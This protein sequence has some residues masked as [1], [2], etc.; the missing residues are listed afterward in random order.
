MMKAN[1][2]ILLLLS[3]VISF[4]QIKLSGKV[5]DKKGNSLIGANVY[6]KNTYF[7]TSTNADGKYTLNIDLTGEQVLVVKFLGYKTIEK[8]IIL[9]DK[10]K[11]YDIVLSEIINNLNSV[12]ITA[13]VF[14][15]S[16]ERKGV[17]LKSL[18]ILTTSSAV[19]DVYGAIRTLPGVHNV[20]DDGRLFVRGGESYETKNFID[21]MLVQNANAYNS[22]VPNLPTRGR[23]SPVL[24]KGISF[25]SG[26]YS[27]EYGQA[28]SS[29]LILKTEGLAD[30]TQTNLSFLSVGGSISHTQRWKNSSLAVI[31]DYKNLKPYYSIFKQNIEWKKYPVSYT[32]TVIFRQKIRK[33]GLFKVFSSFQN[34]TKSII[35]HNIDFFN[36][37]KVISLNN[38]NMY[39][40]ATY[41][42]NY[43]GWILKT[44]VSYSYNYDNFQLGNDKV[45][46]D[47]R[48]LQSKITLS[49]QIFDNIKITFGTK[50][51][52]KIYLQDYYSFFE[53]KNYKPSFNDNN[54]AVFTEANMQL[55]RLLALRIGGRLEYSTLLKKYN[56]APRFSFALKISSKSQF[57][58]AGGIFY[59]NPQNEYLRFTNNLDFE[60][61]IHYVL[62]YQ[63]TTD[64]RIFRVELY[65][66]DYSNLIKFKS[67]NNL[68]PNTYNNNGFGYAKGLDIF[69]RDEKLLKYGDF[70]ISYSFI[71]TKRNY[72]DFPKLAIPT[73]VSKHNLSV[74]Y[75][76]FIIKLKT[77]FSFTYSFASGRTYFNPNN[78]IFLS[79]KTKSYQDLS[80]SASYLTKIANCSTIVHFSITNIFGRDN[81]FGYRYGTVQNPD[82]SFNSQAVTPMAKRFLLLAVFISI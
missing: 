58:A 39:F 62:N 73:F 16:D 80:F 21:G 31:V 14:E 44:G 6:L 28:L 36:N 34:D 26:A 61:A 77:Q 68:D 9:T 32:G 17:S 66:K 37:T 19:G 53:K 41:N 29:A 11:N 71:D 82:G 18:D 64:D 8:N 24:F 51:L 43:F 47:E 65:Y 4:S 12:Y 67:E 55:I 22:Q 79:D 72:K 49:Q 74:V 33:E 78:D 20:G 52:N 23:F 3:S 35:S 7:G 46:N 69:Y 54:F 13:G 75:K 30:K 56:F 45:K 48:T 76:Y 59:Q 2:L 10:N 25:N 81:V 27:A 15:A 5:T 38:N 50:Y 42:D 57:S 63:L 70:W 40:N 1:I 60:R